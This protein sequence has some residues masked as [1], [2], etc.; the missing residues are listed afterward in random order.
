MRTFVGIQYLRGVAATAVVVYHATQRAG[1]RF[2]VGEAGVDLFFVLSGFLMIAITTP[3][4]RAWGFMLSRMQRIVPTYWIAT[5]VF[6]CVALLGLFPNA[7]LDA[8]HIASSYL[9]L[10]SR[11]PGVSEIWPLLV[12]GWTLNFEM[13][14][15]VVFALSLFAAPR[16]RVAGMSAALVA[17][18]AAGALLHPRESAA[19]VFYTQPIL[20]EFVA[21]AWLGVAWK[22]HGT[23]PA[24]WLLVG[25][26]ALLYVVAW[27][28]DDDSY[29]VLLY[30]VPAL[31]LFAGT[32]GIEVRHGLP[33]WRPL[34][35]IGDA[36]Y[37]I[38]LWHT[39]I[40]A[41]TTK[42]AGIAGLPFGATVVVGIV[43]SLVGGVAA[44]RLIEQPLN[45]RFRRQKA[46][47]A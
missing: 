20:L 10:P 45:E 13:F 42:A 21:G 33:H 37:S 25:I 5:T 34:R 16:W 46:A 2:T 23:M 17:I 12:P 47:A 3:H 22:R 8:W 18:V 19:A 38:Y 9:F 1:G 14:F 29:R 31:L 7:R 4:T 26:A 41:V 43:V 35:W 27:Q 11:S 24:P 30:G 36:S 32:L 39:M 15:Y 28:V 6:L 40:L 44:Y